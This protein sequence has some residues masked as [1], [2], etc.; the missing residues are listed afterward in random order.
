LGELRRYL[1]Q[2]WDAA[3]EAFKGEVESGNAQRKT[4]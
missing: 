2:F 3:L 1:D 4:D